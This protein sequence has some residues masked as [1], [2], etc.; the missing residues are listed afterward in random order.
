MKKRNTLK[1]F[2]AIAAAAALS[3]SLCACS[4]GTISSSDGPTVNVGESGSPSQPAGKT[5]Y[6][7]A[8]IKLTDHPSLDEIA[9]AVEKQ[10]DKLAA[11]NNVV[12]EYT[13]SLIHI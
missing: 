7:A 10:L 9:E 6:K 8:I 12:I 4:G 11:D 1:K 3:L 5:T 13:L 2:F